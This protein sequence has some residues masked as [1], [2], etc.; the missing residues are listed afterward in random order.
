MYLL[1]DD[2]TSVTVL[3]VTSRKTW[4]PPRALD[5]ESVTTLLKSNVNRD[6][7]M[8]EPGGLQSLGSQESDTT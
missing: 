8:E 3:H 6:N 5:S 2:R 4:A 7:K 1:P